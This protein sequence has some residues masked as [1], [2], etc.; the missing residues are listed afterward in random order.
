MFEVKPLKLSASGQHML[1]SF[2]LF[3]SALQRI[4]QSNTHG[5][6][7][8]WFPWQWHFF[9]RVGASDHC[10]M[11][12]HGATGQRIGNAIKIYSRSDESRSTVM[13]DAFLWRN[14]VL[15][16]IR[17]SIAA[18]GQFASASEVAQNII[19]LSN[20]VCINENIIR[21]A[22][23]G[24]LTQMNTA[25]AYLARDRFMAENLL[26]LMSSAKNHPMNYDYQ[27]SVADWLAKIADQTI[28][29][30]EFRAG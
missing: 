30:Y 21:W 19:A 20:D 14:T 27:K 25:D 17:Q 15:V 5:S 3:V 9:Q 13:D 22:W 10:C 1:R 16:P 2:D 6:L 28:E 26:I 23:A 7:E 4:V 12:R 24:S 29:F 11:F 8:S 18:L